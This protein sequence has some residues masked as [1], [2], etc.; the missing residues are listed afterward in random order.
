MTR[1]QIG[2]I[3]AIFVVIAF[4]YTSSKSPK[5]K[6]DYIVPCDYDCPNAK[7]NRKC[8]HLRECPWRKYV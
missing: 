7:I 8:P 3:I 6:E 4:V 5:S 2:I 1:V